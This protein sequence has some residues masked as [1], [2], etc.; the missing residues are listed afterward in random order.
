MSHYKQTLTDAEIAAGIP[1]EGV[2]TQQNPVQAA[3]FIPVVVDL[4][5]GLTLGRALLNAIAADSELAAAFGS[6]TEREILASITAIAFR[7]PSAQVSILAYSG[8]DTH[9]ADLAAD[10]IHYLPDVQLWRNYVTGP[11]SVTLDVHVS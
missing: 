10:E 5:G 8:A 2:G 4:A 7:K 9:K 11:A 3:R 6:R 1:S